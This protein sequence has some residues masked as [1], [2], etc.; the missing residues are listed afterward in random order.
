MSWLMVY[1]VGKGNTFLWKKGSF[2][3]FFRIAN[4]K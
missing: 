3:L 1:N 2:I 4:R